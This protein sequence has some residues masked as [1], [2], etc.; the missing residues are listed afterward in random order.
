MIVKWL[1]FEHGVG[2]VSYAKLV[3]HYFCKEKDNSWMVD[4]FEKDWVEFCLYY[5]EIGYIQDLESKG[6]VMDMVD[7]TT[8]AFDIR[9]EMVQ[10]VT[11]LKQD[12]CCCSYVL[13][14]HTAEDNSR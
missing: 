14:S 10:Y 2:Q 1:P 3:W 8:Q 7:E 4:A 5:S 6:Y 11:I 13:F 12:K 9:K